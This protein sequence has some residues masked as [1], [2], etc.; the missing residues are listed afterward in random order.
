MQKEHLDNLGLKPR[1]LKAF[2][3]SLMASL[4]VSGCGGTNADTASSFEDAEKVTLDFWSWGGQFEKDFT[5]IVI[6]EFEKTH[7]LIKVKYMADQG[8]DKLMT[9][10]AGGTP[11]DAAIL[12]RF[13]VGSWAA[14]GELESL[15]SYL[16]A[17][18]EIRAD[19]YYPS[20]WQEAN[21]KGQLY[22]M[23]FGTDA[24]ALYYNK[25]LMKE[26]GLDPEKPPTTIKELDVMAE[27]IF[28][29]SGGA[30]EQVGFI[31]WMGQSYLYT[32][33]F[34]FGGEWTQGDELTPN[35]PQ[36][37]KALEWMAGY[38][39]KYDMAKINAFNDRMSKTGINP[40]WTGKVG[41]MVDGNWI[42]NDLNSNAKVKPTFEWG[43]APMPSEEGYPQTSWSGGWSFAIPKGAR[44]PKEAWELLSFIAGYQGA[45]LWGNRPDARNDISAM[46]RVNEELNIADHAKLKPFLE[47][48]QHAHFRPVTPAG[49]KLWDETF[50]IQG[51][52]LEGKGE[53]KKLLDEVKKNV[54]NE[55][56]K[57][58]AA[59]Q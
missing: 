33:S 53:P 12:D 32:Q 27:Q 54:D 20:A 55:L 48:L 57:L 44:H 11:P 23:P 46:P 28:K 2:V 47:L 3:A 50:R 52:A 41:F 42:M 34:N 59:T 38:A 19:D 4:F 7:P 14:K 49:Q 39:K 37:V 8:T 10:I 13:M 1:M 43:V 26:S 17:D 21:Y 56:R 35:H 45:L 40:F 9:L 15:Q 58:Q 29:K 16:D 5:K 36:I 31:P 30:Y 51:L 25:T 22:A 6:Q 24:R 18:G